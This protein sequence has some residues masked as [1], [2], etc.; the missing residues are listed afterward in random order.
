ML[1]MELSIQMETSHQILYGQDARLFKFKVIGAGTNT[2]H[3]VEA[4]NVVSVETQ[5]L[6]RHPKR[7]SLLQGIQSPS[8]GYTEDA[9]DEY[10]VSGEEMLQ[11]MRG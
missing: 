4:R 1:Q 2:P 9:L 5:Y 6:I 3:V 10:Y 8:L 11:D 7:L